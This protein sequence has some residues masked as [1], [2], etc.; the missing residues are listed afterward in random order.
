[1]WQ[2]YALN[3]KLTMQWFWF[4]YFY[5]QTIFKL[6]RNNNPKLFYFY[7][8]FILFTKHIQHIFNTQYFRIFKHQTYW[9]I[10]LNLINLIFLLYIKLD[11]FYYNSSFLCIILA[12]TCI[13]YIYIDLNVTL[14]YS[15]IKS[16]PEWES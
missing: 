3:I 13:K 6:F 12:Y 11:L 14:Y 10:K 16:L 5:M 2:Y 9:E 1:M 7:F 15:R 8:L 4:E